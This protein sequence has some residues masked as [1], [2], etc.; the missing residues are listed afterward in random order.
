MSLTVLGTVALDNLIT[1]EGKK[2]N[3][4]GGSASHFCMSASHFVETH[5][6][7]V[8]GEDFPEQHLS[9]LKGKQIGMSSLTRQQGETFRWVGEYKADNLNQA[10]THETHL[11]VLETYQP[12]LSAEHPET[13]FV[14][15]ANYDT[16]HQL[17]FLRSLKNKPFV[18]LDS[19][20]LWIDIKRDQ[21]LELVSEVDLFV[22][23]DT[24]AKELSGEDNII[25]AAQKLLS[26]G[27]KYMIVKKG[28]HGV[29]VLSQDWMFGFPAYP[30]TDV[31]DP[32]GAGDTFAGGLMGYLA[33][34]GDLSEASFRQAAIYG[35]IFSS[36]N[37]EGFAMDETAELTWDQVEERK[38]KFLDF[39]KE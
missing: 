3:L 33:K 7:G 2:E 29:L 14:F 1:P 27:P 5:F 19:M 11:G 23:N 21:L 9:F 36:F 22:L 17:F 13:D 12:A 4:L 35:T 15:L 8:I 37:V 16:D 32:T 38:K 18:G 10:I 28:E 20:N 24:E 6:V 39:M 30:V 31:V 25:K 34:S 26:L